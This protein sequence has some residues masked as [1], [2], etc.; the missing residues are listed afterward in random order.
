MGVVM[1]IRNWSFATKFAVPTA[2]SLTVIAALTGISHVSLK[3]ATERTE[4][5]VD[6]DMNAALSLTRASSDIQNINGSLYKSL[7]DQAASSIDA[8]EAAT[9]VAGLAIE[10]DAVLAD[11]AKFRDT[12]A[13]AEK[14]EAVQA[15]EAE[16]LTYKDTIDVVAS[17]MEID[18]S[19]AV[20]F[21]QPF[22]ENYEKLKVDFDSLVAATVSASRESAAEG[23]KAASR[24]G[25]ILMAAALLGLS[26]AGI[27]AFLV[28]NATTGSI[29]RISETTEK[30]ASGDLDVDMNSM[31]RKDELGAIVTALETFRENGIERNR[32]MKKQNADLDAREERAKQIE[33]LIHEFEKDSGHLFE[34]VTTA[35]GQMRITAESMRENAEGTTVQSEVA[36][37]AL[38]QAAHDVQAVAAAS[39]ELSCSIQEISNS[40]DTSMGAVTEAAETADRANSTMTELTESARQIDNVVNLINDIA[41]QTNL[42][43]LNA[44]IEAAR[45]GDAGKGFAVVAS[46]VKMLANQTSQATNQVA[47]SVK[48]IQKVTSLVVT[49]MSNIIETISTVTSI[50]QEVSMS[51]QQQGQATQEISE[52]VTRVSAGTGS[53]SDTMTE[54]K[55]SATCTGQSADEVLTAA[56]ELQEQAEMMRSSVD[57]FLQGIR[58]A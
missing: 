2:V 58:A 54:V 28:G 19:S 40:V 12:L 30:L 14:I 16:L 48:D 25:F 53:I 26:G 49:A 11:L 10:V 8:T 1:K 42:L 21:A 17:M 5:I 52:S 44:T 36:A 7:T 4:N 18:F 55:S 43:A 38:G 50:S 20:S 32:L 9:Q 35:S 57:R 23:A 22:A 6:V 47:S 34:M 41:E 56:S 29:R 24:S 37:D 3:A 27:F 39:E 51:V 33:K 15:I 45:A 31:Q 46:E 13:D